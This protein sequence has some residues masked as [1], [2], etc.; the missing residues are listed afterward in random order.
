[1]LIGETARRQV[2]AVRVV[3]TNRSLRD[4]Q[5]ALALVRTVDL[6]QLVAVSAFLFE[7]GGLSSVAAYGVVRTAAPAVGAPVVTSATARM[8]HGRVLRLLG[9]A[10]ALASAG[11][12]AALI[13]RAT[14]AVVLVLAAV[15][16]VALA[17]FRP[18]SS[19]LMPSLVS[20]PDELVACTAAAGFLDGATTVAGPLLAGVLLGVAGAEWAVGA[21]VV[22]L[23]A[24]ALFAGR[25]PTV[26]SLNLEPT[27]KAS[28]NALRAL[29]ASPE[30]ATIAILA[31][32]QTFVRGALNV[33]V[34]VFVVDAMGLNDGAIGVLLAAIGV[35]GMIALPAVLGIVSTRRMYRSF[36][37]GLALWGLPLVITSGVPRL[38]AAVVLFAIVG[39]GN[40]LVDVSAYSALPRAVPDRVLAKVFGLLEAL[41]QIGMALGAVVAGVLLH[42]LGAQT[43]LLVVGLLLPALAIAAAPLLRR[44]DARLAHHDLEV[45]L[46]RG[47]PLFEDLSMPVLDNLAARLIPAH[48]HARD[49]IMS[50][51]DYGDQ[52]VL[53]VDGSVAFTQGGA[54]VNTLHSGGAF[55]EIAL[56]RDIP[57]TA[58]AVATT[59]VEARTLDRE[60]FLA[61]LGCST[62]API[63]ADAVIGEHLARTAIVGR[64][65]APP[66]DR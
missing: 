6:A 48:F 30:S 46:L 36:G 57:R 25:L 44:F 41:L 7:H 38:A 21:T 10:A 26:R 13:T 33:I 63:R 52:Y 29:F 31:P 51:G 17:P 59:S 23:V 61:A 43:A 40:V 49:V 62:D 65:G 3:F 1:M 8:G 35:G 56:V 54:R 2:D 24:A 58:T 60:A 66:V 34:V 19:A 20:R 22:L 55:G 9:L 15:V 42:A 53:I 28:G 5:V 37:L 45:D 47:Q 50:E 27:T 39:V 12:T 14:A 4:C 32:C 11:I 64:K 16:G 18:I